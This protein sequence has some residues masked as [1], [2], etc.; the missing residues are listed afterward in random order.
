MPRPCSIDNR[1]V[2]ALTC[3]ATFSDAENKVDAPEPERACRCGYRK[4]DTLCELRVRVCE[5]F[6]H[7]SIRF[8][9]SLSQ[10]ITRKLRD[11]ALWLGQFQEALSRDVFETESI[12]DLPQNEPAV[13]FGLVHPGGFHG[14]QEKRHCFRC[15]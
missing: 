11:L 8:Q 5:D 7:V 6:R 13:V 9:P 1:I 3:L 14:L 2:R 4:N 12:G 15:L 10:S